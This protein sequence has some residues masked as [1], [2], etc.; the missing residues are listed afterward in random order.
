M[1]VEQYPAWRDVQPG[2]VLRM[3][4]GSRICGR[5]TV[6]WVEHL[7]DAEQERFA[8]WLLEPEH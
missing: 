3:Y 6:R 4:E 2:D 7:P 5:G 1:F 8:R